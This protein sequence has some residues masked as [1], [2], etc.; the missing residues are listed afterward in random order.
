MDREE[1]RA[2]Q[3]KAIRAIELLFPNA[4]NLDSQRVKAGG[5][6]VKEARKYLFPEYAWLWQEWIKQGK[7][8]GHGL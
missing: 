7:E 1:L 6:T 3:D 8:A 4:V 5:P 2:T